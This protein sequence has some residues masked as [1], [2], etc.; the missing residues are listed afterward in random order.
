MSQKTENSPPSSAAGP[1][2]QLSAAAKRELNALLKNGVPVSEAVAQVRK[3]PDAFETAT[4][5]VPAARKL[6]GRP[7]A[8][9]KNEVDAYFKARSARLLTLGLLTEGQA[10]PIQTSELDAL[11]AKAD[12]PCAYVAFLRQFGGARCRLWSHDHFAVE[13][14][15]L[16]AMQRDARAHAKQ[17][18]SP[19]PKD[20]FAILGHLANDYSYLRARGGIDGTVYAIV[21]DYPERSGPWF[22]SVLGWVDD[23]E[24]QAT[25]AWNDGYFD[26]RPEGTTA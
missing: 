14:A 23:L 21:G 9:S 10:Q 8:T 16:P 3:R 22:A 15:Y 6:H 20:G 25:R 2:R 13:A 26:K 17:V 5:G 1:A 11:L 7:P 19:M 18:G 4:A 12:L 24:E